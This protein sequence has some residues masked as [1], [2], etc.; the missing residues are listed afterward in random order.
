MAQEATGKKR[1]NKTEK[2]K[3]REGKEMGYCTRTEQLVRHEKCAV[4][5][6]YKVCALECV[7]EGGPQAAY[8]GS[9][10]VLYSKLV[11]K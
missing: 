9:C 10:G 8:T 5:I 4:A 7:W 3:E 1:E 2:E 6:S 11:A